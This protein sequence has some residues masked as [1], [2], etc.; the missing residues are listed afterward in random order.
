MA[1]AAILVVGDEILGGH[2]QDTTSHYLAQRLAARG[3]DLDR[4]VT[5]RDDVDAIA[6]ALAGLLRG[7]R[8]FSFVCG[9]IG[10]TPDDRTYEGVAMAVGAP[11]VIAPQ[12]EAWLRQRIAK[13]GY[14]A[15]LLEDPQQAEALLRMVRRPEGSRALR[16]SVGTALGSAIQVGQG[17]VFVLPGVPR[18][19]RAMMEREVEPAYLSQRGPAET[20]GEVELI[21]EEPRLFLVLRELEARY[22]NLRLGSYPQEDGKR[23]IVRARG[24]PGEVEAAMARLQ[25]EAEKAKARR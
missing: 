5:V 20:T 18:E 1:S 22:P 6:D 13:S 15:D 24:D 19:M 3:V 21:G 23:I 11:L 12:D 17:W 2:T 8:D 9:G 25:K 7:N 10:P 16:N 14:G 4:I